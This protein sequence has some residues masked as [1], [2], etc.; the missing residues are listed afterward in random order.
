MDAEDDLG[1]WLLE[2]DSMYALELYEKNRIEAEE[3]NALAVRMEAVAM[4]L[5]RHRS[6][7]LD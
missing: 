3:R 1:R 2:Q 4:Q 6:E 7:G 5:R